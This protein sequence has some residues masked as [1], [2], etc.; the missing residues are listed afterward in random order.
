VDKKTRIIAIIAAVA[1]SILIITSP[2]GSIVIPK[3]NA[4]SMGTDSVK[5]IATNLQEPWAL[6]FGDG[7]IFL[8]EK[9]GRL[10][11][12]DNGILVNDSVADFRVADIAD[13][14]L[15][16][17]T[18]HP[19]FENNHMI[20]IYYTY[21]EGDKLYNKV[22]GITESNNKIKDVKVILDKIPGAKFDNGGVIKFGPDKKLYIGTGDATDENSAQDPTSLAGKILRLNDD[23]SIPS[24]NPFPNSPVYSLGHRNPQGLA[25]DDK[26]ILYETE[27]GPTKNDEINKIEKGKNYGWP[28]QECSGSTEYVDALRCYN[29]SLEPAGIA[30][31]GVGKLNLTNSLVLASLR[32]NILYQLSIHNGNITSQKILLD[33][34]GRIR[35]VGIGPDDYL[36]ILTG[37]TDGQGFPDKKDDKLLRVVK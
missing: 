36:Y 35:E 28:N 25:W 29:I 27:E 4:S 34:L 14:G 24:D 18:T 26:G 22:L 3:P 13:A 9:V 37:N 12:I 5:V 11:V 15:L 2:S 32:G 1:A 20:Y 33:G 6:T 8:T 23:G 17:V 31:Y 10:R 19:D 7:K 30:Y 21:K 16:G